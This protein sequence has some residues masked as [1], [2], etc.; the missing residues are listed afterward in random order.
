MKVYL[1]IEELELVRESCQT[2]R[3]KALLEV[4]Y[5]SGV[6]LNELSNIKKS[7]INYQNM[8]IQVIGKGNKERTVFLTFK[9]LYHLKKYLKNRDDD[10]EYLFATERKPIKKMNNRTIQDEFKKI[11]KQS[12]ID[13]KLHAHLFRRTFAM[14]SMEN[15]IEMSDLQ[16]LLG[17]SDPS[18]TLKSYAYVSEERKQQAFKR[19]HV[20]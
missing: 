10:C 9:A 8:S 17:H 3:Q 13:K 5:S 14:L 11:E 6:R 20:I 16:A 12:G 19:F 4:A 2:L 18:T 7:D 1:T 15:G